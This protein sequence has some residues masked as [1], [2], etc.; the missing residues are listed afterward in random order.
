MPRS[1]HKKFGR[2]TK[3]R[4]ALLKSL[5]TSLI[6][7]GRI[8]TTEAKAKELRP[9]VEKMVTAGKI[10]SLSVLKQLTS[11]LS[12]LSARKIIKDIS[13]KFANRNGGY[14]RIRHLVQR[15]SDG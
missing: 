1:K 4:K 15:A 12:L 9:F 2:E 11:R 10:D 5:A 7:H 13:P 14:T 6:M 8:K 3:Q